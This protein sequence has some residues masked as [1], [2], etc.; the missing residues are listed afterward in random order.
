MLKSLKQVQTAFS[1]LNPEAVRALAGRRVTVGLV[2]A[3]SGGYAEMED[4]LIPAAVPHATRLELMETVYRAGDP[5]PSG[6][7]DVVLYE[8]G[9]ECPGGAFNFRRDDPQSTVADILHRQHGLALP[10]ARQF[11]AFRRPVVEKIVHSVA[12]ENALFAV[13]TALPNVVPTLFELPWVVGEFASD[14]AFL[15][16]N[17]LRMAFM[18]AAA[19]GKE[20]GFANQKAEIVSI[21]AGAFGWRALARELVSKIPFGG[22]VI[23]KGAIAYAGTFVVGKG[24]E[25]YHRA[26]A[27]LTKEQR[28][29]VYEQA[30]ERGKAV[31]ESLTQPGQPPDVR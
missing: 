31:A 19:C 7:V 24:L 30:Y 2:A 11:P 28:E 5:G 18:I 16:I 27:P 1:L 26:R 23:P 8:D 12:S 13:A 17:Q 14:T 22:G 25:H 20:I 4:F 15:T 9:L 6:P 10:L 29:E 3:T 21:A